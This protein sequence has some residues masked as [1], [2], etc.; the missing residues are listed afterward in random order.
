MRGGSSTLAAFVVGAVWIAGGNPSAAEMRALDGSGFASPSSVDAAVGL[1]SIDLV[2]PLRA[3]VTVAKAGEEGLRKPGVLSAILRDALKKY[4]HECDS[5]VLGIMNAPVPLIEIYAPPAVGKPPMLLFQA[6]EFMPFSD[7]FRSVVDVRKQEQE[8]EAARE[9]ARQASL[10]KQQRL[11]EEQ[12]RQEAEQQRLRDEAAASA[13]WWENFW[14]TAKLTFWFIVIVSFIA[15]LLCS[16]KRFVRWYFFVFYPH[17]AAPMV[18]QALKSQRVFDGPALAAAL[19]EVPP[20]ISIFRKVR[21]EQGEALIAQMQAM[22]RSLLA[23]EERRTAEQERRVA[24][25]YERQAAEGYEHAAIIGVQEAVALAAAAL[26]RAK[27]AWRM[28]EAIRGR[29]S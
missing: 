7:R 29:R 19:G 24:V 5:R 22:S 25:Q 6:I 17:P 13:I 3:R 26:E 14:V 20:G 9:A 11:E 4:W 15:F 1:V 23:E 21:L 27:A 2:C 18:R 16:W 28:S 8:R 12:R 10:L